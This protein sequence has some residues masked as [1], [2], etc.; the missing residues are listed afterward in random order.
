VACG[1]SLSRSQKKKK[2]K[3]ARI[4]KGGTVTSEL[5][6]GGKGVLFVLQGKDPALTT[7]DTEGKN[8]RVETAGN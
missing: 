1:K 3:K 7:P 8:G 4:R 5:S 6:K 2:K